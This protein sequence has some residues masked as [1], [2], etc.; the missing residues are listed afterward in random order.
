MSF[1]FER[2][3]NY[4]TK[5]REIIRI[6]YYNAPLDREK[7]EEGYRKQ[8]RFFDK[9]QKIPK[10]SLILCRIQK[11]IVNN[12]IIYEV[13]EDDIHLAVDMVKSAYNDD[14]DAA[15]LVTSDGDFVPA[16]EAVREKGKVVENIGFEKRFSWH[17][18]QKSTRFRNIGKE[19]L[20]Q[21]FDN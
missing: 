11:R 7:D 4:L 18:K 3:L 17:L 13:K 21:F 2:F 8:Q 16:I 9:L 19:D 12:T 5:D 10:F 1:N 6:F 14:Y 20:V 15:I